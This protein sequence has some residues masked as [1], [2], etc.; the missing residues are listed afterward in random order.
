MSTQLKVMSF[1][2]RLNCAID[3]FNA[4]PPRRERILAFL[5]ETRADV[6]GFQE[7]TPDMRAWLVE[8]CPDYYMVGGGRGANYGDEASL[9]AFRKD[10]W[11]AL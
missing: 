5:N 1:N 7:I 11:F 3:G 10:V 6:I 4:F 8:S 9:I 2:M